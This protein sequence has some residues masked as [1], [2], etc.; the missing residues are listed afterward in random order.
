M[1]ILIDAESVL[2]KTVSKL[3][4]EKSS[5][6]ISHLGIHLRKWV[7]NLYIENHKTLKEIKEDI[8]KWKKKM[9]S[10]PAY[11]TSHVTS[12]KLLN[13]APSAIKQD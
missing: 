7:Q 2:D 9:S 10:T 4:I 6:H 5:K 11:D 12:H 3:E 13:Q 8:N 1:T